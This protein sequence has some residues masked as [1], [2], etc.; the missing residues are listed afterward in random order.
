VWGDYIVVDDG[1]D[2]W[3][4]DVGEFQDALDDILELAMSGSYG[5]DD[6]REAMAEAY[7]GLCDCCPALY[8]NLVAGRHNDD[9]DGLRELLD[10]SLSDEQIDDIFRALLIE[11]EA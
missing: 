1:Q 5:G 7:N 6:E 8:S 2:R 3:L 4:V 10:V 9:V 11:V